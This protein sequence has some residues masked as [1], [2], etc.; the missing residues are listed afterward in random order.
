MAQLCYDQYD[1]PLLW[2]D[3]KRRAE[4]KRMADESLALVKQRKTQFEIEK[5][6]EC[7]EVSFNCT[8]IH[9][10]KIKSH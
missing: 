1:H 2:C 4:E 8:H 6:R 3:S 10:E 5:L 9:Q 7:N